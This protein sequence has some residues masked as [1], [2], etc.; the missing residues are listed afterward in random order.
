MR[1]TH[2]LWASGYCSGRSRRKSAMLSRRARTR[3]ISTHLAQNVGGDL[4]IERSSFKPI[5]SSNRL[6]YVLLRNTSRGGRGCQNDIMSARIDRLS[7]LRQREPIGDACAHC[8]KRAVWRPSNPPHS[9]TLHYRYHDL[10]VLGSPSSAF[11]S[12]PRTIRPDKSP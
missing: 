1:R 8:S 9:N 11:Q 6:D 4:G 12:I 3:S 10:A 5:D 7:A 2:L